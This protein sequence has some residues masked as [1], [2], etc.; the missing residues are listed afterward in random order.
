MTSRTSWRPGYKVAGRTLTTALAAAVALVM[1]ATSVATPVAGAAEPEASGGGVIETAE[2]PWV[3]DPADPSEDIPSE[4]QAEMAEIQAGMSAADPAPDLTGGLAHLGPAGIHLTWDTSQGG[5]IPPANVQSVVQAAVDDWNAVVSTN[6]ASVEITSQWLSLGANVLGAGGPNGLV[7][8]DGLPRTDLFYPYS[9]ANAMLGGDVDPAKSEGIMVLSSDVDWYVGTGSPGLSQMDLY[10]VVLHELGHALGFISSASNG[11]GSPA[12]A[13][14]AYIFDDLVRD[15]DQPVLGLANPDLSL[16]SGRLNV[17]YCGAATTKL[18]DP[19]TWMEG[20]SVSHFD[21]ATHP[22]GQAGALMTHALGNGEVSRDL[23]DLLLG[24]M[25]GMGWTLRG[26]TA[27]AVPRYVSLDGTTLR[28]AAPAGC[29][30]SYYRV[31]ATTNGS[32]W[33]TLGTTTAPS[34]TLSVN[35][36]VYQFRVLAID[37]GMAS[38]PGVSIPVGVTTGMVRPVPLDGQVSRLYEAYFLRPPDS[39]GYQ[40]WLGVRALGSSIDQVS[41]EFAASQEFRDRYGSLN[42]A[43]FVD[44]VYRNVLG[45]APDPSGF[46]FWNAQLAAGVSRGAIMAGFSDSPEMVM[47]TGTAAP[48]PVAEAEV[49]RLYVATFLRFP[50]AGGLAY[51]ADQRSRG[52][53]LDTIAGEFVRSPEFQATYGSLPDGQFVDLIYANVLTR[54]ADAGGR[55]YWAGRL[56]GGLSRGA[57]MVGFSQ[58]PEFILATGT[59]R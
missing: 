9:L 15:L 38:G 41:A 20:S 36:G 42:N 52:V 13:S 3:V 33:A 47:R 25:H 40:Y 49:Y 59:L 16:A 12:F 2:V 32:T 46:T 51:W 45:R 17:S 11:G 43:Q 6:G 8:H 57:M 7:R 37:S 26:V 56:A 4:V 14:P 55:D 22:S 5:S 50:D 21:D 39:G 48:N 24:V 54:S 53:G 28:W 18:F 27:P 23:D 1:A 29:P 31:D 10:S 58:S 44:L 30:V 34:F 35:P 19:S